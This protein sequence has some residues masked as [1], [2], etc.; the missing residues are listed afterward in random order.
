MEAAPD[1]LRE[2]VILQSI[3][4]SAVAPSKVATMLSSLQRARVAC[5]GWL[6]RA[7]LVAGHGLTADIDRQL[8]AHLKVLHRI[9]RWDGGA[10]E[11]QDIAAMI[12]ALIYYEGVDGDSVAALV[13]Q[14]EKFGWCDAAVR[15]ALA[16]AHR[17]PG[18]L[19]HAGRHLAAHVERLPVIR[20]RLTGFSTTQMLADELLPAC[21]AEG[22]RADV[23]QANF[24]EAIAELM[25]PQADHDGLLL[26]LDLD[27]MAPRDWRNSTA[28]GF[29]LLAERAELLGNALAA[30]AGRSR[31][32]L[33]INTIPSAPAPT[34]GLL[35]RRHEMGLRR[36]IDLIN[37]RILDAADRSGRIAVIDADQ[38]LAELPL[39]RHIES[40][41]WFY[42]RIAYSADATRALARSFAQAWGLLRRGPVKVV[43][44][45]LDNTLWGGVYGDDGVE[46][47]A[48]G[49]DFPGN[50][51]M[52]MQQECLRLKSQGLLLVALSKNNADA[53][54]VFERHPG[55]VL[56]ADD[57]AATSVNW[58]PKPQ[59]I[60]KIAADL[61]LGVDSFVFLDDSPQERDA[62]RRLCPEVTVPE[63][64]TDPADRPL[65][66]RRLTCTWPVRLT[67]EDETRAA[68]YATGREAS[69]LKASVA[70]LE[71]FLRGLEQRLIVAHVH[72][73]TV[74][75]VAQMHLRTNQFNLTTLRST[76]AE[77]AA[78]AAGDGSLALLG[79]VNDRFGDHGIVIAA[80]ASID[81]HEAVIR[82]LL[83]SCRVI[84]RQVEHA[85]LAE[86]L[87]EL[88][89][90][91]VDHVRA[92]FIPTAK[93]GM[94]RDFYAACGFELVEA[95]EKKSTWSFA[96][97]RVEPPS[98][99]FVVTG[100][101]S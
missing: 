38:A 21:A 68:L 25:S 77:I 23:S 29:N 22:W 46:R 10:Q 37:A 45:D 80:T 60:R 71:E 39:S 2:G 12:D 5:P 15:L 72:K 3:D 51:F 64:P 30:F 58:D 7:L 27:G 65:W 66:L 54:T 33:L 81:G 40:K 94:V 59:N 49:H 56:K 92:D 57:F 17:V 20:M 43:A 90:R 76:D 95:D 82:S 6:L 53:I 11:R 18:I 34:A 67:A 100:W 86:L 97:G 24:G 75:R 42:G 63:M 48:C 13:R 31:V 1:C 28:D 16:H 36:G 47:L 52:A 88:A 35:D 93:N 87:R 44:V 84:G 55:M 74:A 89:R 14:L 79:R 85:F 98:S 32:P 78:M 62:M 26:L 9:N 41:L 70:T 96:L 19:R 69:R 83:M 50:A 91:G 99:A 101:E 61:N 8:P 73:D 4:W